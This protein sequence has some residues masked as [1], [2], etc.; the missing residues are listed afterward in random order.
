MS[1]KQ[2]NKSA[3]MSATTSATKG[4][5]ATVGG[6]STLATN[7]GST[8]IKTINNTFNFDKLS[9]TSFIGAQRQAR[10]ATNHQGR[11]IT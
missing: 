8:K 10:F 6:V 11:L 4:M 1:G 7:S 9:N 2:S 5:A 3:T